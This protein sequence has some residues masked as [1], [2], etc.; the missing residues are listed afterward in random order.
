MVAAVAGGH[1]YRPPRFTGEPQFQFPFSLPHD[2]MAG[3]PGRPDH[4]PEGWKRY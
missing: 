1:P 2:T 4:E 3:Q